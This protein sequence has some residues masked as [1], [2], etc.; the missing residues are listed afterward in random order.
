[1]PDFENAPSPRPQ[2][3][4]ELYRPGNGPKFEE[5]LPERTPASDGVRRKQKRTVRKRKQASEPLK[6]ESF[7]GMVSD[8]VRFLFG[9]SGSR[10]S[11]NNKNGANPSGRS[12]S[13]RENGGSRRK[14]GRG[15]KRS[16][17]RQDQQVGKVQKREAHGEVNRPRRRR[18]R[19]KLNG[20]SQGR[21]SRQNLHPAVDETK[22]Y[23][24]VSTPDVAAR[25]NRPSTKTSGQSDGSGRTRTNAVK[26]KSSGRDESGSAERSRSSEKRTRNRRTK[27][28]DKSPVKTPQPVIEVMSE[29]ESLTANSSERYSKGSVRDMRNARKQRRP[30]DFDKEQPDRVS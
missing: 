20:E 13:L 25:Y 22:E 6:E 2:P 17:S 8:F 28:K 11:A 15:P 3:D 12:S 24:P 14:S 1:M 10:S 7:L 5:K 19:K 4:G 21:G 27:Q 23:P 16:S 18:K 26:R 29:V 30:S 9:S